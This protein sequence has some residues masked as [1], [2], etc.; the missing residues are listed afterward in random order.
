MHLIFIFRVLKGA[1]Q[2]VVTMVL[3]L[4]CHALNLHIYSVERSRTA[5]GHNGS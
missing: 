2:Q 1:E 3:D 4:A 5:G